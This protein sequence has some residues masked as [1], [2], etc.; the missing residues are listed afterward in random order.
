MIEVNTLSPMPPHPPQHAYVED[1][2]P[3]TMEST[4]SDYRPSSR[5]RHFS[6]PTNDDINH[7]YY[8]ENHYSSS[9]LALDSPSNP[10]MP[11]GKVPAFAP[12]GH[13]PSYSDSAPGT[14]SCSPYPNASPY[15]RLNHC[16]YPYYTD[17]KTAEHRHSH[18]SSRSRA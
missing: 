6:R 11:S 8:Y 14:R 12:H 7:D 17:L 5:A 4:Y 9:T 10:T 13:A 2:R 3:Q 16:R 18:P 1:Y 15:V